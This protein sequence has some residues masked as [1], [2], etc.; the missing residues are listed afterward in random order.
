M[1][2]DLS[3]LR[4][5][6][7]NG[8]LRRLIGEFESQHLDAKSQP[9]QFAAGND[10]KREFAKDVAAFAN[11]NGGCIVIGAETNVSVSQP[12]EEIVA[13]KP[14]PA[15]LFDTDQYAKIIDEWLYPRPNGVLIK[16]CPDGTNLTSGIGLIFIPAQDPAGKP[17]LITRTIGDKKTTEILVGYVERHIDRTDIGSVVELHH[18]M[19][20]G[21]NLETTLL[22]RITNLEMLLERQIASTPPP[23]PS[24]P[25]PLK[26]TAARVSRA[27]AKL[28]SK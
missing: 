2:L 7:D 21:M 17:F 3:A 9:Y 23:Q 24:L 15:S 26:I 22:N 28:E 11:V 25:L 14:F 18:A 13:L 16:W 27:L 1:P 20:T 6:I 5:I 19:R 12:G 4:S 8:D 10:A